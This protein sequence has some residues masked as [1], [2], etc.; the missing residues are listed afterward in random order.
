MG[1][2]KRR[3]TIWTKLVLAAAT[4]V[5]LVILAE[6]VLSVGSHFVYPRMTVRDPLLGWKY[7]P[8]KEPVRRRFVVFGAADQIYHLSINGEGFRDD[9][10]VDDPTYLKIMV[11]GD[12]M[13]F[14]ME[15]EQDEIFP[16]LLE[17]RLKA[18]LGGPKIDVM[19]LGITAFGT[20]QQ[21]LCLEQYGDKFVPDAVLLMLT[22]VNDFEDNADSLRSDRFVPHF[23]IK[24]DELV[25]HGTPSRLE[26]FH[27]FL[28]DHSALYFLIRHKVRSLRRKTLDLSEDEKIELMRR[29]LARMISYTQERGIPFFLFYIRDETLSPLRFNEIEQFSS[30]RGIPFTMIPTGPLETPHWNAEGHRRAADIIMDELGKNG[31]LLSKLNPEN[32]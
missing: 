4:L 31:P 17:E 28:R 26:R 8:T 24:G 7:K 32:S 12:S 14:G 1:S 21:L 27:G 13:T 29:L 18:E 22:E 19:N 6:I 11:L 20:A 15:V 3:S 10:F 16:A 23:I 9:E 2:A 25:L 30:E 5:V